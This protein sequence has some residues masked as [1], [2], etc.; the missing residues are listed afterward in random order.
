MLT[1]P[2]YMLQLFDRVLATR[3]V[4]TLIV[5]TLMAGVAIL[6]MAALEVVRM[7]VM[8]RLGTW[9]ERRLSGSALA[10]ALT[11]A[12]YH[13]GLPSAQSLR[14]LT[15]L[16]NYFSSSSVFPL[17]DAPWAPVFLAHRAFA[18]SRN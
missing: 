5:L 11:L 13:Q 3:N 15:Q 14:D 12:Q 17:L 1:V 6:V 2:L 18:T 10:G 4:D 8:A 9:L 16:R 7:G